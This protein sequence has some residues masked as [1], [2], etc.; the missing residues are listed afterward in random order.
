METIH[1]KFDRFTEMASE[2]S[3]LEPETNYFNNDD[4]SA[5]FTTTPSK[6]DMD[7][8][9]HEI[10]SK[11][12]LGNLFGP[13]YEEYFDK[14]SSKMSINSNAQQVLN[15]ED[16]P[17]TSLIVV[18]EHE[19]P[20]IVTKSKEQ[21]S[22]ISFNEADE[23]NQEDSADFDAVRMFA[24]FTAHKNIAIFKMDV[25]TAFLNG[26]LKEEVYVS[27]LDG[28][29]DLDFP[30]H[31]YRLKKALY[32]LKQAPR[33]WYDKLS[34][35]LI[36]H[37]FTKGIV[38][39]TL[40]TRCHRGDILLVQVYVDDIIFGSTNPDFSK[41]FANLMKYNF[42]VSMIGELKFFLGLQVHQSPRGIFITKSQDAI[43]ILK[44]HGMDECVSMST[45]MATERLDTDLQGAPTNQTTYRRMIGGL[46]YLTSTEAEYVS[47]SA[48]CAQVIWI[49]TQLLDYGYKYNRIPMYYDSKS[50]IAI[51][52]NPVQHSRT[53]HIDIRIFHLPQAT[54]NNNERFVAAPKFSRMV[55]FF[56]NTLGFTLELR[57]PFNLKT[58][59]LIQ[60]WKYKDGAGM[61]IP[62]W[63]I[64]DAMKL[65]DHYQMLE[66]MSDKESPKV[67][68]SAE[69]Q[70]VNI[71]EEEEELAE[72][73]YE[74]KRRENGSI[75]SAI[76]LRD[77]DDPHDDA[78][79]EGKNS[80]KRQK[81]SEHGTFVFVKSSFGQDYES[82]PCLS[83]LGSS[84][85]EK[86]VMSHHKFLVFIF[87]DDDIEERTS[88]WVDKYV[89]KFKPYAQYN[90][91]HWK[92]PHANI[93]YIKKQKEPR[94][95]KKATAQEIWLRVQQMM[96]GSNIGIRDKK[97]KL[98]NEWERFSSTY[99]ESI[100]PY[101]HR[102]QNVGN[103]NGLI[104]VLEIANPN[105]NQIRNGNVVVARDEGN[106]NRD[107]GNQIRCYNCRGLGHLARNCIVKPRRRDA[108]YLQTQ[109]MIAQNKE[110]GFQLQ[111]KE[112]A[113]AG[114]LDE[115]EEVNAN[116]IL[117]ANF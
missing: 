115:I 104:F 16:S 94:K 73:D 99:G 35:F 43:E 50:A 106:A 109:L 63:M 7:N 52:C 103:Q 55:P 28:F 32:S 80:V 69:V 98:F 114:D 6:E 54:D 19:A 74:L 12:D 68:I 44:K 5:A 26:P 84:G 41:R 57:S 56:L 100:E 59:G 81:T 30:Y 76:H 61:K 96:K 92:N 71:N 9:I 40:F 83:T 95:L 108:A 105:T 47:L 46:M 34:S 42:E 82:E 31:V 85:P 21:T 87:P 111:A 79:Q 4:S 78:H 27:Q 13:M 2:H 77:Q 117:M 112:M 110:A 37:H 113:A 33:A 1:I 29:V 86:I 25:K 60:P 3:C 51:S 75:P 36:E 93:F 102:V 8:L 45:P 65:T 23:F 67:E 11:E 88:R 91:E 15:H 97:A 39:S 89:K 66:P 24:T 14:R 53:K 20:P 90:V 38:D 17:L 18:E 64:T 22:L 70:P 101:Y 58:T 10:P 49:R 48:C 116:S 62:S 107:N 72:N